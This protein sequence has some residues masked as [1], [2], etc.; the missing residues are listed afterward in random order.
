VRSISLTQ[1]ADLN[2]LQYFPNLENLQLL[3]CTLTDLGALRHVPKLLRLFVI[4][5]SVG[6]WSSVRTHGALKELHTPACGLSE[7]TFFPDHLNAATVTANPLGLSASA[8]LAR[9]PRAMSHLPHPDADE[10]ELNDALRSRGVQACCATWEQQRHIVQ[11]PGA[12]RKLDPAGLRSALDS[13]AQV[14]EW[15]NAIPATRSPQWHWEWTHLL[16]PALH[17]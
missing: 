8:D 12:W 4:E 10:L 14:M 2:D 13:G 7:L 9:L 5:S 1:S 6:D 11:T 17:P 15:I 16:N 3:H